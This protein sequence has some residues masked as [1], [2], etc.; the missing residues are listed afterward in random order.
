[1]Q[2]AKPTAAP[3]LEITT[4]RQLQLWMAEQRVSIVLTTYQ[5]ERLFLLWLK[6]DVRR[7]IALGFKTGEIRRV[8]SI[9]E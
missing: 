6:P 5:I 3:A 2:T 9:A 7:P 4:S 8:V 1:M